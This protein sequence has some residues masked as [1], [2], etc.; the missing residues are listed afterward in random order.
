MTHTLGAASGVV[1]PGLGFFYNNYLNCFDPRPGHVNSLA[2]GKT[3]IT[4]MVPSLAF[5]D[6]ELS[7]VIGA[8][9]GPKIVPGGRQTLLTLAA[10]AMTPGEAAS[11]PGLDFKGD[12]G[13][14]A[15]RG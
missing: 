7:V 11:G 10:Q 1:T 14:A 5:R 6:G 2:P 15:R 9:G 8:P 4:M 13:Q 3:R 12:G